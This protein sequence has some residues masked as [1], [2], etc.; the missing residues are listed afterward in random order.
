METDQGVPTFIDIM[1]LVA[2]ADDDPL[3]I[4]VV[5]PTNGY[6]EINNAGTPNDA[7]D[8]FLIYTPNADFH[9]EDTITY[10]V[11]DVWGASATETITVTVDAVN[12][13]PVTSDDYAELDTGDTKTIHVLDN[14]SDSDS[15]TLS[16]DSVTQGQ[17]GTV[18]I[19][20]DDVTYE[21][22]GGFAGSDWFTYTITD[23][24]GHTVTARVDVLVY[25]AG[26]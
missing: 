4:S 23:G 12:Q 17:N 13:A 8:D 11:T 19:V 22:D 3:T 26:Q 6:V 25:P 15:D 10:T 2:D 1:S 24:E 14:D 21:P 20:G 18:A 9:G 16:I 5:Q 7:S